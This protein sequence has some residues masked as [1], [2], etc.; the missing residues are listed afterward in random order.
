MVSNNNGVPID[1]S[2]IMVMG[3]KVSSNVEPLRNSYEDSIDEELRKCLVVSVNVI[4]V[5]D[6]ASSIILTVTLPYHVNIP[7]DYVSYLY[8]PVH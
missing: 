3:M 6:G 8:C 2:Q 5:N 1:Q 4:I 7:R